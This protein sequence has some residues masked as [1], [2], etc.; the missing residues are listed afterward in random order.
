MALYDWQTFQ[1]PMIQSSFENGLFCTKKLVL[2]TA[3]TKKLI[4]ISLITK[5]D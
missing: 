2:V 3:C 5:I 4:S 1:K